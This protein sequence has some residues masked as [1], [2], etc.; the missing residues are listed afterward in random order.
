MDLFEALKRRYS[1]REYSERP[2]SR[3]DLEKIVEVAVLAPTARNEQPWEFVVVTDK[4]TL[5]D[6]ARITDHGKFL[7]RAAASIIVLCKDTKYYLEDGCAA[8]ENIIL[9]AAGLGIGSCWIAGDKKPY[10]E[11]IK[12]RVGAPAELRLISILALGY[13][14]EGGVFRRDKRGVKEILHWEKF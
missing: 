1:L 14:K 10:G 9:A 13:P 5:K 2:V 3:S 12:K 4:E 11:D 7:E 6:L 8:T